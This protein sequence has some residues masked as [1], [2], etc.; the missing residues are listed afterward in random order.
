MAYVDSERE[1]YPDM[2]LGD[3]GVGHC[4]LVV[5]WCELRV[6]SIHRCQV[7]GASTRA[8]ERGFFPHP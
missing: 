2:V 6:A 8:I 1:G 5:E 4:G 3:S 7:R